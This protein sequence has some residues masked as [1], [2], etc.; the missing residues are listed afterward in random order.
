MILYGAAS[1]Q[2]DPLPVQ[3]LTAGSLYVHR[4]QMQK[5]VDAAALAAAYDIGVNNNSATDAQTYAG[6]NGVAIMSAPIYYDAF[7]VS[8]LE[9]AHAEPARG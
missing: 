3:R 4:T 1:G 5:A 2:P 6:K 7:V 9:P 8:Y